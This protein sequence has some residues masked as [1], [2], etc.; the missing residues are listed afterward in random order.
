MP[1]LRDSFN[2]TNPSDVITKAIEE[3]TLGAD[4]N[5]TLSKDA[6]IEHADNH[7]ISLILLRA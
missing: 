4:E 7:E 3:F 1:K 6:F 2:Y 5:I